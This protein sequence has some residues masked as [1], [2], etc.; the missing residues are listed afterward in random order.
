MK[1]KE[2][3]DYFGR[4]WSYPPV[5]DADQAEVLMTKGVEDINNSIKIIITTRLG[6]RIMQPKFGCAMDDFV[7]ET[8]DSSTT[9]FIED[10][11]RT[12]IIYHEARID[13]EEVQLD[14]NNGSGTLNIAIYYKLRNANS[15]FN[16]VFPYYLNE[17]NNLI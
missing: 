9:K 15:R 1:I 17:I 11:I 4:G 5:F 8:L 2:E 3:H 16:F 6:E 12:A 7:F 14:L 10:M 13:L